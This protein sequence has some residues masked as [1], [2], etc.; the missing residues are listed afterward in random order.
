MRLLLSPVLFLFRLSGTSSHAF[1]LPVSRFSSSLA[2]NTKS[3]IPYRIRDVT[4]DDINKINACNLINLQEHYTFP[5]YQAQISQFPQLSLIAET[6]NSETV[7]FVFYFFHC[8]F[9]FQ[10]GYAL[11]KLSHFDDNPSGPSGHVISIAV[12]SAFR[13]NG[14]AQQLL[15]ILHEKMV[16]HYDLDS[17]DLFC[18]VSILFLLE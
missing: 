3:H 7:S 15:N 1:K 17:V 2:F 18:R 4:L 5:F 11:G 9:F 16:R 13:G 10:I 14:I 8:L 12:N 6:E